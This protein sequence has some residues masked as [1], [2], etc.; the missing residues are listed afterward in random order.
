MRCRSDAAVADPARGS[1]P[2]STDPPAF[3]LHRPFSGWAAPPTST[4]LCHPHPIPKTPIFWLA[5]PVALLS[6]GLKCEKKV[7]FAGIGPAWL[8]SSFF[9]DIMTS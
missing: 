6:P 9:C 4:H 8:S 2:T 3:R 5:L 7:K 1:P